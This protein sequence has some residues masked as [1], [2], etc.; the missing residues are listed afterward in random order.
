[1]FSHGD[2]IERPGISGAR[3]TTLTGNALRGE[4]ED[5]LRLDAPAIGIG[6]PEAPDAALQTPAAPLD[7][8]QVPIGVERRDNLVTVPGAAF[9]K[10]L[11]V[12][13]VRPM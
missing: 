8:A 10:R 7:E 2:S 9:R 3:E 4:G 1:M 6:A 13:I 12:S 11:T 5:D